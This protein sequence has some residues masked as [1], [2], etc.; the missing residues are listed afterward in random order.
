[1]VNSLLKNSALYL[2]GIGLNNEAKCGTVRPRG[3]EAG[4]ER[5]SRESLQVL[6]R[7]F[8]NLENLR[9]EAHDK[10]SAGPQVRRIKKH[11]SRKRR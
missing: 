5:L 4:P 10:G 2:S 7:P 1:M 11:L 8:D 3:D 6:V 9:D